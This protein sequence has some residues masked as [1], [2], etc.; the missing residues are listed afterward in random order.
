MKFIL[1]K[2]NVGIRNL[3]S[4]LLLDMSQRVWR[5]K[6]MLY[7]WIWPEEELHLE[8][9]VSI[10]KEYHLLWSWQIQ[11]VLHFCWSE[12]AIA[13]HYECSDN[14][15]GFFRSYRLKQCSELNWSFYFCRT[16]EPWAPVMQGLETH[17]IIFPRARLLMLNSLCRVEI[18]IFVA[19]EE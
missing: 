6:I 14:I 18:V 17:R 4:T 3:F 5:V 15:K 19:F 11:G 8:K 16:C 2:L 1:Y 9:S 10:E 13:M 12:K 7:S